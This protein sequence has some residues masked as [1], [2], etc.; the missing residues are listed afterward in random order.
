MITKQSGGLKMSLT[1]ESILEEIEK[2]LDNLQEL[3]K[4]FRSEKK[5]Q[6]ALYFEE[7]YN[8]LADFKEWIVKNR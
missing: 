7:R 8:E 6:Y 1:V 4:D 5:L 3:S 2:R